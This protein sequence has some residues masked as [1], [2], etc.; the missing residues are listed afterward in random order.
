MEVLPRPA[1]VGC[2]SCARWK[3]VCIPPALPGI[4]CNL[5]KYYVLVGVDEPKYV[6]SC[7]CLYDG[8]VALKYWYSPT[9]VPRLRNTISDEH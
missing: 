6:R 9:Q 8:H 3:H 7:G 2:S 4:M 5:Y 1:D